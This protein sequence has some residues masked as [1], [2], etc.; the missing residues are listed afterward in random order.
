VKKLLVILLCLVVVTSVFA[1]CT[2]KVIEISNENT[3]GKKEPVVSAENKTSSYLNTKTEFPIVNKQLT[4]RFMGAK[5]PLQGP[6][7]EM[8][9]YKAMEELTNIKIQF[10]MVDDSAWAEKKKLVFA[11]GNLPDAFIR[12]DITIEE[13]ATFGVQ[14]LIMPLADLIKNHAP[15][16]EETMKE[17]PNIRNSSTALDGNMYTVP[18]V[19][20]SLAMAENLMYINTT[21]L[22][23]LGLKMP[24][25]TDDFYN[26]LKKFKESNFSK[27]GEVVPLITRGMSVINTTLLGAFGDSGGGRW[28]VIDNKVLFTPMTEAYKAYITYVKKLYSEKLIDQNIF[29]H[30]LEQAIIKV[31]QE[32]VGVICESVCTPGNLPVTNEDLYTIIPPLT[33]SMNSKKLTFNIGSG[34]LQVLTG[35]FAITSTNKYPEATI[36]WLDLLWR[37]PQDEVNGLSGLSMWIGQRGVHWDYANNEKNRYKL[38]AKGNK[39]TDPQMYILQKVTFGA[40]GGPARVIF[41]MVMEGGTALNRKHDYQTLKAIES[42]K[43]YFPYMAQGFPPLVRF[44]DREREKIQAVETNIMTYVSQMEVKFITGVESLNNWD[45]FISTLKMMGIEEMIAMRQVAYVNYFK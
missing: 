17:F 13:E 34:G 16:L 4:L 26:V 30:S 37:K 42:A 43:S 9:V 32:R 8:D 24:E 29:S 36:R 5:N 35:Q 23:K 18:Y 39:E 20:R 14:G 2:I 45:Q 11:S 12:A 31:I 6:W 19:V 15:H 25:N 27:N 7:E 38:I 21:W 3:T 28:N 1:G 41:D 33:S 10:D 22:D 40:T 44:T